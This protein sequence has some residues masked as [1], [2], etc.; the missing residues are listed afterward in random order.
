MPTLP[1]RLAAVPEFTQIGKVA[2]C[3]HALPEAIVLKSAELPVLGERLKRSTFED[4][5]VGR[6]E[7]C[8]FWLEDHEAAVDPAFPDLG[9]LRELTDTTVFNHEAAETGG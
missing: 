9:L 2:H 3:V 1:R 8:H 4:C 7:I 6:K 5:I